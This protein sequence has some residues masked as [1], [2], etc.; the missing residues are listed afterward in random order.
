MPEPFNPYDIPAHFIT[1]PEPAEPSPQ[2]WEIGKHPGQGWGTDWRELVT[3]GAEF[4][5]AFVGILQQKDAAFVIE[6]IARLKI[7]TG[8]L[9]HA[10][11]EIADMA[12][13]DDRGQLAT[14]ANAMR[15]FLG[16]PLE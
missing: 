3:T 5:P 13:N 9:L 14:L 7:A 4:S 10:L 12:G 15:E 16:Y 2:P 1:A 8:L 6:T 11:P